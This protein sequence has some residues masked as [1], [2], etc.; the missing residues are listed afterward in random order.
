MSYTRL[1][2]IDLS[3]SLRPPS[4]PRPF[5]VLRQSRCLQPD[6]WGEQDSNLRRRCHQ[7]YS[8]AP[9][10]AWV[11]TRIESNQVA[12]MRSW[13][14]LRLLAPSTAAQRLVVRLRQVGRDREGR[15]H[16]GRAGGESRTHNRRFTKPVLCRLSYAS[17]QKA[18]KFP[19]IPSGPFHARAFF[20]PAPKIGPPKFKDTQAYRRVHSVHACER[21]RPRASM[22]RPGWAPQG[23]RGRLSLAAAT[24][25]CPLS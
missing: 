4:V 15:I 19:T 21:M 22:G 2:L 7:I 23:G 14:R 10:A 16:S 13:L 25:N 5:L 1:F 20:G 3:V 24:R 11:S 17:N 9:L 12:A 18:V 6:Q 8:L